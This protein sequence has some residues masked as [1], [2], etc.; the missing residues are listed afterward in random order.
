MVRPEINRRWSL[1]YAKLLNA[2]RCHWVA[3]L[4]YEQP[5]LV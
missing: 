4:S 3:A 1:F 2:D 5:L